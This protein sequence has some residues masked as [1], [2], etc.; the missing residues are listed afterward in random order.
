M[1]PQQVT[2]H[3]FVLYATVNCLRGRLQLLF[4]NVTNFP[5]LF[6]DDKEPDDAISE[7][8]C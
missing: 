6:R 3:E 8:E 7:S 4:L 2:T 5:R 1:K